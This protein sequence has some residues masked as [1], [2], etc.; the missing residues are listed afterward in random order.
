ML[1]VNVVWHGVLPGQ[2]CHNRREVL[3]L[4]GRHA[5]RPPRL[6]RIEAEEFGERVV[7]T[8]RGPDLPDLEGQ[9]TQSRSLVFRFDGDEI[10]SMDA[11][12]SRDAAFEF[13]AQ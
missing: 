2:I 3:A 7:V 5:N 11:F 6:T 8:V 1:A 4:L 12:G 13:A 10:V 9:P